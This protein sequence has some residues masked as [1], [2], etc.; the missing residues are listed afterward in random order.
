MRNTFFFLILILLIACGETETSQNPTKITIPK[1]Q[2]GVPKEANQIAKKIKQ[3]NKCVISGEVLEENELWLKDHAKLVCI[4]ADSSTYDKTYGMSHR[5]LEVFDTYECKT[6]IKLT[7]PVNQ[8]PDFPYYLADINYNNQSKIVAIKAAKTVYCLDLETQK[9]QPVLVPKFKTTRPEADASSGQI[10]RL[11]L[12]EDFLVGYAQDKGTFVFDLK[13]P[14]Q[15][16]VVLPFAEYKLGENRFNSLFLLASANDKYQ[17]ILPV[18]DW[19]EE[20]FS[21]NPIYKEPI[22]ISTNIQKSALNNEFIVLREDNG[23]KA[24]A[25]DLKNKKNI[26]LPSALVN[27]STKEIL[28]WV[29]KQ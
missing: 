8:T 21:I 16:K 1:E 6:E 13:N 7:L 28:T 15:S 26:A 3:Q 2:I 4:R 29:K 19:E 20:V 11:E 27:K 18:Y 14:G 10:I 22:A 25:I 9:M 24:L 5:I 12:W 23:K 17:A